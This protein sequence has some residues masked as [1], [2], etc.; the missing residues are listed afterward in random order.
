[1]VAFSVVVLFLLSIFPS[2]TG[3]NLPD[4]VPVTEVDVLD[5]KETPDSEWEGGGRR[6]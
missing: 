5:V 1:M 6:G 4:G 2:P 3:E